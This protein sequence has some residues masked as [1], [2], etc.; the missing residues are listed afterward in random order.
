MALCASGPAAVR[1][2]SSRTNAT[3]ATTLL[4]LPSA[5]TLGDVVEP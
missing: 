5:L 1:R 2:V 3:A 4:Q